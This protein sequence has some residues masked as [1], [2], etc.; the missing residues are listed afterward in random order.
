MKT[1]GSKGYVVD[2]DKEGSVFEVSEGNVRTKLKR[3]FIEKAVEGP[4]RVLRDRSEIM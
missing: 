3:M 4:K 2:I 1:L